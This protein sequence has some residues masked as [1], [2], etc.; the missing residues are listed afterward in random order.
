MS[1]KQ[2]ENTNQS[3]FDFNQETEEVVQTT[4]KGKTVNKNFDNNEN[5]NGEKE[6]VSK[7]KIDNYIPPVSPMLAEIN[8]LNNLFSSFAKL[9]PVEVDET[10]VATE[11]QINYPVLKKGYELTFDYDKTSETERIHKKL[12][13]IVKGLNGEV[14]E[15]SIYE[16]SCSVSV[17]LPVTLEEATAFFDKYLKI[18]FSE[19]IKMSG[20]IYKEG[21][22]FVA[23]ASEEKIQEIKKDWVRFSNGGKCRE[24]FQHKN[25]LTMVFQD[26]EDF[27]KNSSVLGLSGTEKDGVTFSTDVESIRIKEAE[28]YNPKRTLSAD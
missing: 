18:Q 12:K 23:T 4:K 27:I 16:E 5:D 17:Q 21:F 14:S 25:H 26:A 13:A 1:K 8:T 3:A 7:K 24:L 10:P 9:P 28:N 15:P 22:A 11:E 20:T 6:P 19:N 2:S